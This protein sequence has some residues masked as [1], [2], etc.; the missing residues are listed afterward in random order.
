[1]LVITDPQKMRKYCA[2]LSRKGRSIGFVPTMGAL[3]EGHLELV[4]AARKRSDVVIVSIFVNPIQFGP[5]EDF[6]KYPRDIKKDAALLKKEK[7]DVLFNPSVEG[8]T[9]KGLLS[10]VEA[11]KMGEVLCG[12]SRPGHFRG[13]TTIVAKFFNI[14]RPDTAFFGAKDFQQQAIIRKMV[15]DLNMGVEIVTVATVREK[16]GLAKSSRN[17][18]LSAEQRAQAPALHASLL[19]AKR[20][21]AAGEKSVPKIIV[22]IKKI[23]L[24]RTD[25]VVDYVSIVDPETFEEKK[26]IK[27]PVLIAV[28]AYLGKTRLIDNILV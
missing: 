21:I 17:A 10:Y 9:P 22:A 6:K 3:H 8:M 14:I 18:Y 24:S 20:M 16:D 25:F 4:K 23:I 7:V 2:S 26:T 19:L 28:A 13:V 5:K 1:M 11:G 15:K 27:R 12:A